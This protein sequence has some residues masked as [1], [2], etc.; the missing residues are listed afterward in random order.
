M[1]DNGIGIP[2]E[3]VHRVFEPFFT[4]TRGQGGTGL[5]LSISKE[6]I[7]GVL[8]GEISVIS[9]A[10]KGTRFSIDFPERA[11]VVQSP[12]WPLSKRKTGAGPEQTLLIADSVNSED[13]PNSR[14]P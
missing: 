13:L 6:L 14:L 3:F 4:T 12:N 9:Q 2:P 1:E 11:P 8:G 7:E 10:T 5:G